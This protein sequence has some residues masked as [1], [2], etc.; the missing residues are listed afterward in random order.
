MPVNPNN[1]L[2]KIKY[3]SIQKH[4]HFPSLNVDLYKVK[5]LSVLKV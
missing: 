2:K 5:N 4:E 1:Q 3:I